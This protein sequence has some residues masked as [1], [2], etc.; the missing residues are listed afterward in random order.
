MAGMDGE[1]WLVT[2]I[3]LHLL[4]CIELRWCWAHKQHF[5]HVFSSVSIRSMQV[6]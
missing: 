4:F 5:S 6:S 1:V 2:N 3:H